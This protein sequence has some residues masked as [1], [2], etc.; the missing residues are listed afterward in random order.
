M[1]IHQLDHEGRALFHL[2]LLG[3]FTPEDAQAPYVPEPKEEHWN[4][5]HCWDSG[6]EGHYFGELVTCWS[7]GG[8]GN[9]ILCCDDLCN[10]Q[11]WCMHGDNYACRE[12]GG[13]GYL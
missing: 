10:G 1:E 12:C 7:C 8:E 9:E 6:D 13:E 2:E 4:D 3:C 5:D 11:G